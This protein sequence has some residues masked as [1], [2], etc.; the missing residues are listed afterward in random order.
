MKTKPH[1]YKPGQTVNV[2][3]FP[4]T[5]KIVIEADSCMTPEQIE[6]IAKRG[7]DKELGIE[8]ASWSSE[9]SW[10]MTLSEP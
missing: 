3:E 2:Y 8:I 7:H 6:E 1:P 5:R 10:T 4:V 9:G